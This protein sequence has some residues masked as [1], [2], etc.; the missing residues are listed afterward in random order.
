MRNLTWGE[1]QK[2][3]DSQERKQQADFT[4]TQGSLI[5]K[6]NGD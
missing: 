3:R 6:G 5:E 2:K 4:E 1:Q